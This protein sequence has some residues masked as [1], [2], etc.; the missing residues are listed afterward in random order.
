MPDRLREL[1]VIG[2]VVAGAVTGNNDMRTERGDFWS[3]LGDVLDPGDDAGAVVGEAPGQSVKRAAR[4]D[5]KEAKMFAG[6]ASHWSRRFKHCD[7]EPR[8]RSDTN[9]WAL[10]LRIGVGYAKNE[11]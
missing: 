2:E 11:S 1:I 9:R 10:S 4:I 7:I 6:I 8:C 3:D 5:Y